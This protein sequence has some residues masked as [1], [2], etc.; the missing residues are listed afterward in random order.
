MLDFEMDPYSW[1]IRSSLLLRID[2]TIG[3]Q[4]EEYRRCAINKIVSLTNRKQK[5][6]NDKHQL[7]PVRV[8][9]GHRFRSRFANG[10]C[11][12]LAERAKNAFYLS[13]WLNV[14][15]EERF[16]V[17]ATTFERRRREEK[18]K[19]E[20]RVAWPLHL[21]IG[22]CFYFLTH[23]SRWKAIVASWFREKQK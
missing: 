22:G 15:K 17:V 23:V 4:R 21:M 5:D 8:W 6:Q 19:R 1:C 10:W 13:K 12:K 9:I 18:N 16:S 11:L 3:L 20:L 2:R 7:T 14:N